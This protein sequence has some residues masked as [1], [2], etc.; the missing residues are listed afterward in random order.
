MQ[1]DTNNALWAKVNEKPFIE[2]FGERYIRERDADLPQISSS[3]LVRILSRVLDGGLDKVLDENRRLV[4]Q[5]EGAEASYASL[6][7]E[8]EEYKRKTDEKIKQLEADLQHET[9]R[10]FTCPRTYSNVDDANIWIKP[11]P[12]RPLIWYS[13]DSTN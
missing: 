12:Q 13:T 10:C 3:E 2:I 8:Y 7:G 11:Y 1:I 6:L 5:L 4:N 9:M